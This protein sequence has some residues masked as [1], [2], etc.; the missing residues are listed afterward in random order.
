MSFT[1]SPSGLSNL[2][3]FY[4]VDLIIFTEGGDKTYTI[5]EINEGKYNETAVDI[6]FWNTILSV[7]NFQR[8]FQLRAIGSKT[9]SNN[10]C[11]QIINGELKNVAVARD[12][13]LDDFFDT[14]FTSPFI[15]YT[16]GYSWENDVYL[17]DLTLEQIESLI[18]TS[19]IPAQAKLIVDKVY[20][21]FEKIGKRLAK[22]ELIFRL[23][24]IKF[25]SD[26]TGERFFNPKNIPYII[27]EEQIFIHLKQKKAKLSR[28]IYLNDFPQELCPYLNNY[29][30][31]LESLSIT[32]ITYVCK[33]FGNH[34]SM[35][36]DIIVA[37]MIEK[38]S[39]K[40][41]SSRD[42]YYFQLVRELEAA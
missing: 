35:P 21:E 28:P 38:F 41:K 4:N 5:E 16:K 27:N 32:T 20:T 19:P 2:H 29:G 39:K 36:K 8:K 14:K 22:V 42:E 12:R 18:F 15:L 13:D 1:R 25:I 24:N 17:K 33:K 30:K 9:A 34:K 37:N 10:I 11:E 3:I 6:K 23:N 7:N 26:C 40:L 31:L